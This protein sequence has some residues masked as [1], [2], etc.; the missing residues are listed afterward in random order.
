MTDSYQIALWIPGNVSL[1]RF[2]ALNQELYELG[3]DFDEDNYR[4]QDNGVS[5][6][7]EYDKGLDVEK[8]IEGIPDVEIDY[9]TMFAEF[10]DY[11]FEGAE[12]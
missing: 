4:F 12:E 7:A 11:E 10:D 5:V 2:Y 3:V 1:S 9:D 8:I 6:I